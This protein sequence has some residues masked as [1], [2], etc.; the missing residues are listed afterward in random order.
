[1]PV[2]LKMY[3]VSFL[4]RDHDRVHVIDRVEI[5]SGPIKCGQLLVNRMASVEAPAFPLADQSL[6]SNWWESIVDFLD[7]GLLDLTPSLDDLIE[8][9]YR[10]MQSHC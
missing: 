6:G 3:T 1:M 2:L 4:I 10:T 5:L 8:P 9:F 7:L